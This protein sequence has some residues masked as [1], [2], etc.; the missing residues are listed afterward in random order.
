MVEQNRHL[1]NY[2]AILDAETILSAAPTGPA[3]R[4]VPASRLVAHAR[5]PGSVA[6]LAIERALRD[7]A[8]ARAIYHRA[9][10]GR[11]LAVSQGTAAAADGAATTRLI[12]ETRLELIEEP[13]GPRW[14]VLRLG[15]GDPLPQELEVRAPD[16]GGGRIRLA[17]PVADIVQVP[18]PRGQTLAEAIAAALGDPD[19]VVYLL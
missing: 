17:A 11:A 4:P 1:A 14:L 12:G 16:G 3:A 8:G 7:Q 19:S 5:A 10:A 6:D 9:L 18:L 13:D 2:A 15:Q